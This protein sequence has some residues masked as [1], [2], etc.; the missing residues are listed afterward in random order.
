M[1]TPTPAHCAVIGHPIAH[2]LSPQIHH[3][4]AHSLGL[5]VHYERIL[6]EIPDFERT[7]QEFFA[8]GGH[9]LNVTVPFKERAFALAAHS[10]PRAR[11]AGAV[12]TLWMAE[13]QLHGCNTDGE[14][15]VYDLK[16]LHADPKGQ[17]I[18]IIGAGGA[19][20]GVLIPLLEAGAPTLKIINRTPTRATQIAEE[21]STQQ[22][23]FAP[24]LAVGSLQ[25]TQGQWDIVINATSASL[26]TAGLQHGA[27][28]YAPNALAY[29]MVYGA[30]PTPFMQHAQAQ[31]AQRVADGLGMLVEQA[32]SS[33]AIWFGQRPGTTTVRQQLRAQL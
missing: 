4:F 18:L 22:P 24:R 3:A 19:T 30:Q 28:D 32:A 25:D 1:N 29:D 10:S 20:R 15:L 9:G 5:N 26:G 7:V 13:G 31:G 27:I 14:G 6:S 16:K 17:R 33:F 11:L 12:N 8:R 2:S 23:Q 21:L